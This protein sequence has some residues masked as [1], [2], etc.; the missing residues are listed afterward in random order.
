MSKENSL[1]LDFDLRL[2]TVSTKSSG[3]FR[4][5]WVECSLRLVLWCND[6]A[7]WVQ[8]CSLSVRVLIPKNKPYK[9]CTNR[10][11]LHT[12]TK[13]NKGLTK[14]V[15]NR[16][17]AEK[18]WTNQ[19][20]PTDQNREAKWTSAVLSWFGN[21]HFFSWKSTVISKIASQNLKMYHF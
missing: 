16:V 18:K 12:N 15:T 1:A 9:T 17:E 21:H 11:K 2:V 8:D 3:C 20:H 19:F 13:S 7:C 14:L 4:E 5:Y 10:I 6:I